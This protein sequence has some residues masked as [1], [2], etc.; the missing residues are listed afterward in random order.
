MRE[1][2]HVIVAPDERNMGSSGIAAE[3]LPTMRVSAQTPGPRKTIAETMASGTTGTPA[4][5]K[6]R[7]YGTP[8]PMNVAR[9]RRRRASSTLRSLSGPQ[10]GDGPLWQDARQH[11]VR[12][13][14][15][16]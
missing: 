11:T 12:I 5:R 14:V 8:S 13:T 7:K 1:V 3:V 6:T 15:T 2:N 16:Q 9:R 10:G 4:V